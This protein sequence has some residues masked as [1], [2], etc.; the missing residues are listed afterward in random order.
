MP[1][2]RVVEHLDVIED[3][4]ACFL[5]RCIGFAPYPFPLEQ[6]KKA[7]CHSVVMAVSTPTHTANQVMGLEEILPV[8]T[9]ELTATDALLKVKW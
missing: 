6:L 1:A 9:A 8:V 4:A 2:L 5:P 3:I 7:F